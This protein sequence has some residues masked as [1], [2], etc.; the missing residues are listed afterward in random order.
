MDTGKVYIDS[1]GDECSIW[2]IVRRE[3]VWAANRIQDGEKAVAKVEQLQAEKAELV[4]WVNES[5]LHLRE[6]YENGNY[7]APFP[8]K[9]LIDRASKWQALAKYEGEG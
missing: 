2:Q 6:V 4:G 3:P 1:D 5:L 7:D 9:S 8:L